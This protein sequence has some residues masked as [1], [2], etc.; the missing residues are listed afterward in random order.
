MWVE[1]LR[2]WTGV[3]VEGAAYSWWCSK[4]RFERD[5]RDKSSGDK[6]S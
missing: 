5:N 4:W 3:G 1:K 6:L 2:S